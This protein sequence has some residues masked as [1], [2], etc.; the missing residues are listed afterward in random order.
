MDVRADG[1]RA[2]LAS[3]EHTHMHMDP[4]APM[5]HH[6]PNRIGEPHLPKAALWHGAMVPWCHV[7]SWHELCARIV[8]VLCTACTWY[9]LYTNTLFA[10]SGLE[11][12]GVLVSANERP[13]ERGRGNAGLEGAG[14]DADSGRTGPARCRAEAALV[15]KQRQRQRRGLAIHVSWAAGV[16]CKWPRSASRTGLGASSADLRVDSLRFG[17]ASGRLWWA[18]QALQALQALLAAFCT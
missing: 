5:A 12:R 1:L 17:R 18:L 9:L 10:W 11:L 16:V 4:N 15:C 3:R 6:K 2:I 8:M 14:D 13:C 7:D